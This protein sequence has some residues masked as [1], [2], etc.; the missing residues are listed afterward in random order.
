MWEILIG[1]RLP[2]KATWGR[3]E[4]GGWGSSEDTCISHQLHPGL[5]LLTP[6][7]TGM[8]QT[9]ESLTCMQRMRTEVPAPG[10]GFD[11]ALAAVR[12]L[13]VNQGDGSCTS[14]SQIH[15]LKKRRKQQAL[16][17]CNKGETKELSQQFSS[18][19]S[20]AWH[21]N[22]N[23]LVINM[24]TYTANTDLLLAKITNPSEYPLLASSISLSTQQ[25][26]TLV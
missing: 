7:E 12:G 15:M 4:V 8:V 18:Y 20:L 6:G 24:M 25:F 5:Q 9:S 21:P 11:A 14:A 26:L 16:L 19:Q 13:G 3:H 17:V 10:F 2:Y 23:A 22:S 1:S